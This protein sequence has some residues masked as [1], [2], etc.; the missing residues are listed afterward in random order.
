VNAPAWIMDVGRHISLD[1]CRPDRLRGLRRVSEGEPRSLESRHTWL[2]ATAAAMKELEGLVCRPGEVLGNQRGLITFENFSVK[3][4]E[5][6]DPTQ[7][8]IRIRQL[9]DQSSKL[10]ITASAIARF[11]IT[12][13]MS[14]ARGRST[15]RKTIAAPER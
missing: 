2:M 5:L 10:S 14:R 4:I 6:L 1:L 12:P 7:L 9:A 13:T 8:Q 15:P 11:V 3:L